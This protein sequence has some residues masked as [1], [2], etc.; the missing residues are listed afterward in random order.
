M[1]YLLDSALRT[2]LLSQEQDLR[3]GLPLSLQ[4]KCP[5]RWRRSFPAS[6][7]FHSQKKHPQPHALLVRF[8]VRCGV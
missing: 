7:R 1:L 4:G 8:S 2:L 6:T 5:A 3:Y